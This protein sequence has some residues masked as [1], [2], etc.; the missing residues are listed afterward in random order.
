MSKQLWDT[1]IEFHNNLAKDAKDAMRTAYEYFNKNKMFKKEF[2]NLRAFK[3]G[4]A[5]PR[6]KPTTPVEE[7]T[8]EA[9]LVR[10]AIW[11][12]YE[13]SYFERY[14]VKPPRNAI[15]NRHVA[16]IHKRL[17]K[18]AVEVIKFFVLHNDS[19][20]IKKTHSISL[21]L[22]DAETLHTQW[23]KGVQITDAKMKQFDRQAEHQATMDMI[24][25]SEPNVQ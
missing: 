14:K 16:D 25:K 15:I 17:G 22:K 23:Q 13:D 9:A 20:Y 10:K 3:M 12:A 11:Q 18:D 7:P 6:I 21:A 8:T 24:E 19:F 2:S 1:W 5:I 4:T